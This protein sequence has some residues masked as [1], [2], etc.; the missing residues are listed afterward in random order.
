VPLGSQPRRADGTVEHPYSALRLR[1]G[2]ALFGLVVC[3][4][5]AIV[6]W[7][8]GAVPVAIALIVLAAIAL[9][10]AVVVTLRLRRGRRPA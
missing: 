5:G 10:D 7:N 8:V 6:L 4:V 1:L 2:L 3:V 9:V